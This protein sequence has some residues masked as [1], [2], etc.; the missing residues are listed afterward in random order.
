MQTVDIQ[1]GNAVPAV[2]FAGLN[3]GNITGEN[4]DF[5]GNTLPYKYIQTSGLNISVND[6]TV[7]TPQTPDVTPGGLADISGHWAE[8]T[9]RNLVSKKC[10]KRIRRRNFQT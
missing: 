3:E 4:L 1:A 8:Q 2:K 7:Y 9:I 6:T 5:S 10:C